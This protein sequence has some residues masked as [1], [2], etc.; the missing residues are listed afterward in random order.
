[1]DIKER[2]SICAKLLDQIESQRA[3]SGDRSRGGSIER[4]I[5]DREL[6]ELERDIEADPGALHS[7]LVRVRPR[8][9]GR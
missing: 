8:R 3:R 5:I 9:S 7:Q 4:R 2:L 1:M 6:K